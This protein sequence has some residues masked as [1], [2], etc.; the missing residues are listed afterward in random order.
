MTATAYP[1]PAPWSVGL[2]VFSAS[3]EDAHGNT[4]EGWAAP[5]DRAVYG[6]APPQSREPKT[7]GVESVV[8]DLELFVPPDWTSDPRDRVVVDGKTY[9]VIGE[10]E[11]L[12]HGP[13]G[14]TPGYVVNLS[15]AE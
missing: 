14:F 1:F 13:F 2:R 12:N 15:R 5:V 9:E 7:A 4:G 10:P 6:W 3:A 11:D 8:V